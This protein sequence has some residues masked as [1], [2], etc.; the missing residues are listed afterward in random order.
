[1]VE[2]PKDVQTVVKNRV[3]RTSNA[4]IKAKK[5]KKMKAIAEA[6]AKASY[7]SAPEPFSTDDEGGKITK[8]ASSDKETPQ[9]GTGLKHEDYIK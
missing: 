5:K 8:R 6:K 2:A 7:D 3:G 1:L 4:S 9:K